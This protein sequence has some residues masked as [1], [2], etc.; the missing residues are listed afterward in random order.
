MRIMKL[1]ILLLLSVVLSRAQSYNNG[2]VYQWLN[3]NKPGFRPLSSTY[4]IEGTNVFFTNTRARNSLSN[5]FPVA[6][7]PPTGI[8]SL[9]GLSGAGAANAIIGMNAAANAVE[10]KTIVGT[11]GA[12]VT[13]SAGTITINAGVGGGGTG[14][15][16]V[17]NTDSK[18]TVTNGT[19][20]TATIN[21]ATNVLDSTFLKNLSVPGSRITD[22]TIT[23]GKQARGFKAQKADTADYAKAANPG[24]SA[25]GDLTGNYPNPTIGTGKV[26]TTNILDGTLLTA[27]A[28]SNFKAPLATLADSA[29]ASIP[30]SAAGGD[31]TGTYPNPTIGAGKVTT[32]NILDG[33]L[34]TA[35]AA[36]SFKAPLAVLAD[37]A[38]AAPL[39]GPA[40][41]DFTGSYPNPTIGANKVT[42]NSILDGTIQRV[43]VGANFKSPFADT[44]DDTRALS[45][46]ATVTLPAAGDTLR[47]TPLGAINYGALYRG[48]IS[49]N[50]AGDYSVGMTF[51]NG[52]I[53]LFSN[54]DET[55]DKKITYIIWA[56][57]GSDQ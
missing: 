7:D 27:D 24:G 3:G 18:L 56:K 30:T 44:S 29:K 5:T 19:G 42:T 37:S 9:T 40:G 4:L 16:A 10:Y 45:V 34:L 17:Q 25:A 57:K 50:D 51:N 31:L 52:Y 53:L 46:R 38:K 36:A 48:Q 32:T 12:I 13:Y 2:D 21:L 43:D 49:A 41:G 39:T 47:V 35:D 14:I 11:G 6:F 54:G 15:Q 26:T 20:P 22:S 33:T 1:A 55:N 28:A 23:S 8:I